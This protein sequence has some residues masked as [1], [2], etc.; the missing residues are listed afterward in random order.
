M[1]PFA[2]T[3]IPIGGGNGPKVDDALARDISEV[4]TA[5]GIP[6][7]I[8]PSRALQAELGANQD[9]KEPTDRQ[10]AA[11][12]ARFVKRAKQERRRGRGQRLAESRRISK[13]SQKKPASKRG[14]KKAEKGIFNFSPK[15]LV[16]TLN[17]RCRSR[18]PQGQ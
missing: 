10:L 16:E 7:E 1:P 8:R 5:V 3:T 15:D 2:M 18:R 6:L 17:F 13:A 11:R 4:M 12:H 9:A 14:M